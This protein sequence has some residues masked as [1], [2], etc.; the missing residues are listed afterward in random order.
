MNLEDTKDLMISEDYKER[1]IAE[2]VQ[3]KVRLD[4]LQ[5][6]IDAWYNNKLPGCF[7]PTCPM[8]LLEDQYQAMFLYVGYLT[9]RAKLE[10]IELPIITE[11]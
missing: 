11:V 2:Y 1:F 10:N 8:S 9:K 3:T 4:R 7:V 5:K 6:I